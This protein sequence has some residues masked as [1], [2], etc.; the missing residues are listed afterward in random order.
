MAESLKNKIAKDTL[1]LNAATVIGQIVAVLQSFLLM[2]FF[3]PQ[4]YGVWLGFNVLVLYGSY[5]HLGIEHGMSTRLL[6]HRGKG[7]NQ[8]ELEI[9]NTAYVIW[10][11]LGLLFAAG[12]LIYTTIVPDLS[13]NIAAGLLL[14]VGVIPLQQQTAF[15][16]RWQTT[17]R[18]NFSV[19]S[20]LAVFQ[21][22]V[23]FCSIIP[24][25]YFFQIKGAVSG[26]LF[27]SFIS[28]LFIK[29][30]TPFKF[31][32]LFSL[33]SLYEMLRYGFPILLVVAGGMLIETVDRLLIL[34]LLGATS[35]GYY[36]VTALGGSFLYRLIS[37]AGTAL[38]P[39]IV[40]E[41]GRCNDDPKAMIKFLVRPTLLFS[42]AAAIVIMALLFILPPLIVILFPQYIPGITAFYFFVP[43][44]FFLSIILAANNILN[45][46]L[47]FRHK[48]RYVLYIQLLAVLIEV[49]LAIL[50][51]R[52][53]MGLS[54][55]AMASTMAYAF[56]GSGILILTTF[57]VIKDSGERMIFLRDTF[58]P[59]LIAIPSTL[60]VF[61]L[62]AKFVYEDHV[63][64]KL[65][66]QMSFC[67]VTWILMIYWLNQK[68]SLKDELISFVASVRKKTSRPHDNGNI[69]T[70]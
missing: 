34:G 55:I 67:S 42:C 59:L 27:S 57:Y 44:F 68:V 51:V 41:M 23:S 24:L 46:I 8:R 25:A 15:L 10:T 32:R 3:G 61:W 18:K 65:V 22:F 43:G 30:K 5:V 19:I 13:Q 28:F 21:S 29:T 4:L 1:F 60:F 9:E 69:I 33:D 47:I 26:L 20:T 16:S 40:E 2:R 62:S 49:L 54:G 63:F 11:A 35:L 39:H 14:M 70:D 50:M 17:S 64:L 48:Q 45:L 37:Q 6:Y 7:D 56:Y 12:V 31:Q 52:I 58:I 36:G 53:D 38:A 66:L